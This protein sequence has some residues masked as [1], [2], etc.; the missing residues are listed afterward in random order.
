MPC[1]DLRDVKKE[2]VKK[3]KRFLARGNKE[4]M[5]KMYLMKLYQPVRS[6]KKQP[7]FLIGEEFIPSSDKTIDLSTGAL[8]CMC[9][10]AQW[11]P[12]LQEYSLTRKWISWQNQKL[13]TFRFPKDKR[14]SLE[15]I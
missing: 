6:R 11:S 15:L 5:K 7:T 3:V 9:W 10:E 14:N 13:A 1:E 2:N 4:G 8:L 12:G